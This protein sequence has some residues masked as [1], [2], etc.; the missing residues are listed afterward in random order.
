MGMNFQAYRAWANTSK[1]IRQCQKADTALGKGNADSAMKHFDK[2]LG[3]FATA[4]DHLANAEDDANAKA[5]KLFDDGNQELQKA[6]DKYADGDADSAEKHYE[7]ALD[8]YDDAL[9]LVN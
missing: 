2:A 7:K 8:K 5:G 6:I 9:D 3:Y 4:V 1:G